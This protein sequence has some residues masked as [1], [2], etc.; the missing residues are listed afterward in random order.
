MLNCLINIYA[1][2]S[3][4]GNIVDY[5]RRHTN[6]N[7]PFRIHRTIYFYAKGNRKRDE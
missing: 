3:Q 4:Y 2:V 7:F 1:F 5:V 6:M